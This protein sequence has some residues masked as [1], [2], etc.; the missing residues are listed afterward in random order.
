MLGIFVCSTNFFSKSDLSV[1]YLVFKA[2]LVVLVLFSLVTN[3]SYTVFVTTSF[4]TKPLNLLKSTG[5]DTNLST[6]N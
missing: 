1:L 2:N 6:F 3:L 4:F 5:T